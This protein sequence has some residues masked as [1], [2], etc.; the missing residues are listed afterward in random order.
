MMISNSNN[1]LHTLTGARQTMMSWARVIENQAAIPDVFRDACKSVLAEN[2]P[3]PYMVL[4]PA[5]QGVRYRAS[6][7][8]LCELNDV[9]YVWESA[10]GEIIANAYPLKTICSLEVGCILLNSWLTISGLTD[11]GQAATSV[12]P[13]NTA[14]ARHIAPFI[15]KMRPVLTEGT[16]W[17]AELAK[18]DDLASASFKFMNFARESLVGGEKVITSVWQPPIREVIFSLFGR[19]IY[20]N[21]VLAHLALLTDQEVILIRDDEHSTENR[22]VR[23]GGI[24]QYIPLRHISALKL[25]E[26]ASGLVTLSLILACGGQPLDLVFADSAM[27]ALLHFQEELHGIIF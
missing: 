13:F 17:Q 26:P 1:S 16:A 8:V 24:W 27:P 2:R 11:A 19:S 3:F 23:Y 7:K 22:G 14:T 15:K 4:A 20:R 10:P 18:L 12:I 21:R 5:I 6:E 9:F 25:S